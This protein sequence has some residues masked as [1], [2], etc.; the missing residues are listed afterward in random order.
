MGTAVFEPSSI[1]EGDP[2]SSSGGSGFLWA[3]MDLKWIPFALSVVFSSSQCP[4]PRRGEQ[5]QLGSRRVASQE[6]GYAQAD[7]F[8]LQTEGKYNTG[9]WDLAL[10]SEAWCWEQLR[11]GFWTQTRQMRSCCCSLFLC[12]VLHWPFSFGPGPDP[13]LQRG[14]CNKGVESRNTRDPYRYSPLSTDRALQGRQ[15]HPEHD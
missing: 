7:V 1:W 13:Q 6:R 10:Q 12:W 9:Y 3:A 2:Q 14:Y 8:S 4:L 5:L 15:P 11:A